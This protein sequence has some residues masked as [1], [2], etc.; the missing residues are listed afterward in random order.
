ME[1]QNKINL[2]DFNKKYIKW[3]INGHLQELKFCKTCCVF[4][5]PRC[6]HCAICDNCVIRF[7]HH[8]FWLG[9]CIGKRNYKFF[10]FLILSLVINCFFQIGFSIYFILFQINNKKSLKRNNYIVYIIFSGVIL[11]NI[12]FLIFFLLKLFC[13]HSWL[14]ATNTTFNDYYK[15]KLYKSRKLNP[16]NLFLGYHCCRLLFYKSNKSYLN[17]TNQFH[18]KYNSDKSDYTSQ[19]NILI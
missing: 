12:L 8:C 18:Y 9:N 15:R 19:I 6:S 11:Y 2:N 16:F 10:Y 7:D 3:I 5:S 4:R 14:L 1:R 13:V 17:L